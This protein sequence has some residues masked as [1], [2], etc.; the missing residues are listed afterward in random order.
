MEKVGRKMNEGGVVWKKGENEVR[1]EG[2][3]IGVRKEKNKK[4]QQTR[5]HFLSARPIEVAKDPQGTRLPEQNH[6]R[7]D[8]NKLTRR[9]HHIF[10]QE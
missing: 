1:K 9:S 5:P 6:H 4:I 2:E 10:R 3:G 7:P 8:R